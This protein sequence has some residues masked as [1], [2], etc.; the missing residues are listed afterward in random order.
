MRK[1]PGMGEVPPG[2]LGL[3]LLCSLYQACLHHYP[4][5]FRAQFS[6]EMVEVFREAAT[7]AAR[8]GSLAL[9][10]FALGELFHLSAG[11]VRQK[12]N[13]APVAQGTVTLVDSLELALTLGVFA[14]PATLLFSGG[15]ASLSLENPG[16]LFLAGVV[17][18]AGIWQG[19]PRWSLPYFGAGIAVLGYFSLFRWTT[20]Q[21]PPAYPRQF[22][23]LGWIDQAPILWEILTDGMAW[24]GLFL[25]TLGFLWL[26]ATLRG[27]FPQIQ[28]IRSDWTQ[29]SFILYGEAGIGLLLL[30]DGRAIESPLAAASLACLAGGAILYVRNNQPRR[31]ILG[32]LLGVTLAIWTAAGASLPQFTPDWTEGVDFPAWSSLGWQTTRRALLQWIWV[33]AVILLPALFPAIVRHRQPASARSQFPHSDPARWSSP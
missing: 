13:S 28:D 22:E 11:A 16:L 12:F 29:V 2:S 21:L 31:Q 26:V 1:S 4:R 17:L 14:L 20:G 19:F 24:L 10:Q 6:D 25:L 5:D 18:V 32:L 7:D 33:S 8:Q 15:L 30:F 9:L 27:V 3:R 23:F